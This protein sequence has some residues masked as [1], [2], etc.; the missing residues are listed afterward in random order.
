MHYQKLVCDLNDTEVQNYSNEL[1]RLVTEQAEIEAEKKE[2]MSDF[3]AKINKAIADCRVLSR[4]VSTRKEERQTECDYEYDYVRGTVYTIRIDTGVTISSRKLTDDERQERL[5]FENEQDTEGEQQDVQ[6]YTG[7]VI[8]GEI[9]QIE[10]KTEEVAEPGITVCGNTGC[11]YHDA[12]EGNGCGQYEEV[13]D[14]KQAV[15][16]DEAAKKDEV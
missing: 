11:H 6:Y 7:P 8:D 1:A 2:V 15:Q 13:W 16:E 12:T 5:D 3:A 9:L 14:C 4:K 10:H